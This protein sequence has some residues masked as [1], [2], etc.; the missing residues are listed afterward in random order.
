MDLST[1]DESRVG[2]CIILLLGILLVAIPTAAFVYQLQIFEGCTEDNGYRNCAIV[3]EA[4]GECIALSIQSIQMNVGCV[5]YSMSND[6]DVIDNIISAYPPYQIEFSPLLQVANANPFK[7]NHLDLE[8]ANQTL[9]SS[10]DDIPG[11]TTMN[12]SLVD[13]TFSVRTCSDLINPNHSR[14]AFH[15]EGGQGSTNFDL[16]FRNCYSI[17][18]HLRYD[19]YDT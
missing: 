9:P 12:L 13:K 4:I 16:T 19:M 6:Y 2:P 1:L 14:N 11:W 3:D 7:A 17:D 5:S 18:M 10:C 8:E 15:G